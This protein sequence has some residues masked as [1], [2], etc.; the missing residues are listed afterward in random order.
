MPTDMA[1]TPAGDVY[2]SDGYGNARVVHFDKNGKFV[3]AWGKP[4]T[5]PGEF[6][7]PHSIAVD[8]KG[9]LYVA[10]RNNVRIQVFDADGKFL[11]E[12]R[13]LLVPWGLAMTKDDELWACGSSPMPWR[14]ED[15]TLGC[16]PKDQVFMRFNTSGKILQVW[17]VPKGEDGKEKP[18]ELNWVHAIALDS[19]GN[20]YAGDINGKRAQKF[21]RQR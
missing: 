1:I 11:E 4:G 7:I 19:Q 15:T 14:D 2:V 10:D 8:S 20:L 13:D 6:S 9:R 17:T 5:K 3:K 18:G 12:W 21:V 16:P